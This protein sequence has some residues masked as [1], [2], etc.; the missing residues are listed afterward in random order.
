MEGNT[1]SDRR[2]D[3]CGEKAAY[4]DRTHEYCGDCACWD[5]AVLQGEAFSAMQAIGFA[6]AQARAARLTDDQIRRALEDMLGDA[7]DCGDFPI[8]YRHVSSGAKSDRPWLRHVVPLE[9]FGG[10]A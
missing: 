6:V 8:S 10:D 2:C 1:R 4:A 7:E 9:A 5:G 3:T